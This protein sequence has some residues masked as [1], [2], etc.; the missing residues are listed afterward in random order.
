[1]PLHGSLAH[2]CGVPELNTD[3]FLTTVRAA[4]DEDIGKG[5]VTSMS[6]LPE[7]SQS[8]ASI[9]TR[10]SLTVAGL[11]LAEMC[12]LQVNEN[13]RVTCVTNEGAT[14]E[15]D[16]ALIRVEG[17]TQSILAAERTALN[18]L[19][20][21]S[22]IATLT[23]KYM[24]AI[25]GTDVI[26][27]DTRKTT[28][29]WRTLEKHAV[30]CGGGI[31]HRMGLYDMVLIKD[32]HLLALKDAAN[33]ISIA[34]CHA[35]E[36]NPN[37]K[38]EVEADTLEQAVLAAEAGAD[39]ILLDNMQPKQLLEAVDRIRDRC[40]LEASGGITLDNIRAVAETGVDFISIGA[41]THSARAVDIA[42]ELHQ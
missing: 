35:R 40:Q 39:I 26:L 13:L 25:A 24:A 21:L 6:L 19:Q 31:N 22:G 17:C 18:F 14:L 16:S 5:D 8:C 12:F 3:Q 20:H 34:V 7:E 2:A 42:L 1:M 15:P 36:K 9:V 38:I 37:K 27:M 4:L 41:L 33:P 29:G 30:A 11:P 28:P 32:N 10:E 23:T